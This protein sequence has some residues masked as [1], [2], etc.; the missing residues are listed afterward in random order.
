L[1]SSLSALP[2]NEFKDLDLFCKEDELV[3]ETTAN[4]TSVAKCPVTEGEQVLL[5]LSPFLY[6]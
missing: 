5:S 1:R 4:G 6:S 3:F 2:V